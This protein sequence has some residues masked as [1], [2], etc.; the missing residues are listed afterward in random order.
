MQLPFVKHLRAVIVARS[1]EH[2]HGSQ[3]FSVSESGIDTATPGNPYSFVT[4]YEATFRTVVTEDTKT[5][6][7]EAVHDIARAVYG[8]ID[9]A[10]RDLIVKIRAGSVTSHDICEELR[11]I[12]DV[13]RTGGE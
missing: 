1:Y 4:V 12:S 8:P 13:M 5:M 9:D 7:E 10:I 11:E 3:L 6:R 2:D